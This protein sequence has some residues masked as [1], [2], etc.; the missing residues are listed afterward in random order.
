MERTPDATDAADVESA[1]AGD[2]CAVTVLL[3]E[4]DPRGA[5]RIED[6]LAGAGTGDFRV[7]WLTRLPDA[8]DR[9]GRGGV[10]VVLVGLD[11][12]DG[13]GLDAFDR[14]RRATPD[15][16]VLPL[17]RADFGGIGSVGAGDGSDAPGTIRQA[18]AHWLPDAL[19][20]VTQRKT[21]E[22]A[23]RAAEEILF[24][25]KERAEVTLSSI[26]DAVL[27][28]D[29]EGNVTYLNPM[30]EAL[31]GWRYAE[32]IG[33]PLAEVFDIV[34]GTTRELADN[35]AQQAMR[36]DR[37]VGLAAN[38]V[39]LCRD[40]G[41]SGIE[42]SAAPI[43]DRHG[44]VSGAVI[45]FRD[46]SQSRAMT[47]RMAHLA[48]HDALTGL[49][50]RVLLDERVGQAIRLA[51][52]HGDQVALLFVDLDGFKKI[53]DSLGHL[54]GDQVLQAV[55]GI[56]GSCVRTTD[57]VCRHGGDEF[58]ILL[59]EIDEREDA[60]RV[61]EKVLAAFATPLVVD[62]H[63]VR[64][65]GSIGIGVYPD[66]GADMESLLQQADSAMYRARQ[67]GRDNYAFSPTRAQD[68][69]TPAR[70]RTGD[71][72]QRALHEE[73]LVL[74]YQ[75][76]IDIRS[77]SIAG[78]EALVR[79]Q[80]PDTGLVYP[81]R[82]LP[83]ARKSGLIVPIGAWV[84]RKACR[85]VGIW[86]AAGLMVPPVSIN[87]SATEL[88]QRDFAATFIAT[89]RA[90]DLAPGGIGVEMTETALV[91]DPEVSTAALK[92]LVDHGV[93]VAVDDFGTGPASLDYL[94]RMAIDTIKV[95]GSFVADIDGDP[96]SARILD[97]ITAL[98]KRLGY[99]VVA[100]GVETARQH[101][102]L[103]MQDCDAAQ[104]FWLG[105]PVAGGECARL[106]ASRH[107][108]PPEQSAG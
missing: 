33:R 1:A 13:D 108:L 18:E 83:L 66:D 21:A 70:D 43:H 85:Q 6:A 59:A 69:Q 23:L 52:R 104:G 56:L 47:R 78:V 39:L 68:T 40:G 74:H 55:A 22:A 44:R 14:I 5:R 84:L 35:P 94:A 77:G 97:A 82:L 65:T 101:A 9:L 73:Q 11:Q 93:P 79:W 24:E 38:C 103:G 36:E 2:S 49:P 27:V 88:G 37:T 107:D 25:E 106:L 30:A 91:Q 81:H 61:A 17:N 76:Q 29:S 32:A 60:A 75:P 16:L 28:T 20:Y 54:V 72:L 34:D 96:E 3:V 102:C 62:G 8:L 99:R 42:D 57:T 67:G 92:T 31:T 89:L 51:H 45:V 19:R 46:V 10:D 71:R 105:H 87:V 86:Q 63:S 90:M 80:D 50:N 12:P 15:A 98:G 95:H 7:E 64:V 4:T 48:Q 100:K 26:G 53:N 58:A 41:E